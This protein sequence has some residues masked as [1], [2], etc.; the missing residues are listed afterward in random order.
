MEAESI[1]YLM[2]GKGV[3]G[4]SAI[5]GEKVRW[6]GLAGNPNPLDQI[7]ESTFKKVESWYVDRGV[8]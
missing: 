8:Q 2:K 3:F 5:G 6:K 7:W 1:E 4:R